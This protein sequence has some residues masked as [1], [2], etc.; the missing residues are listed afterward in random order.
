MAIAEM[1]THGI[2]QRLA[3]RTIN[4]LQSPA[5]LKQ[6]RQLGNETGTIAWMRVACAFPVLA[7]D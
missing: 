4:N 6:A 2:A 3:M 7:P 1:K 5:R